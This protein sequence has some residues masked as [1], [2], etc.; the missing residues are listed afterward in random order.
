MEGIITG[1]NPNARIITLSNHVPPG[2]VIGGNYLLKTHAPFFPDGTVHLVVIDPGVGSS[3]KIV[4]VKT[5]RN[6]FV[7][8]DNGL[9]SFIP[10]QEIETIHAVTNRDYMLSD[11]S[12]VFHGR[13]IMAPAAA[14]LS[15]GVDPGCF[16]E[17]Q[18]EL[19]R[20]TGIEPKIVGDKINGR[21]IWIDRYGNLIS[22]IEG[23]LLENG[24]R[25]SLND[26]EIGPVRETFSD[27]GKGEPLAYVGSGGHLEIAVRNG[28]AR[29][30]FYITN[31][32]DSQIQ[33]A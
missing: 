1:L 16:G 3:R 23:H 18:S 30:F 10:D 15:L 24:Q 13:D 22:N 29:D 27:V 5:S 33:V 28:S 12:R 9:F 20:I 8:P 31:P 25:V 26:N 19:V 32:A 17:E 21:I 2:D 14:Y 7:G 11:I 6:L 4:A